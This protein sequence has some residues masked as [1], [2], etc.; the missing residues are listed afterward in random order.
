MRCDYQRT[1]I[2]QPLGCWGTNTEESQRKFLLTFRFFINNITIA[3]VQFFWGKKG[4]YLS[5][6]YSSYRQ[7]FIEN[8]CLSGT[9]GFLSTLW[10]MR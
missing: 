5:I 2:S 3:H 7:M 1:M 4:I 8:D 10:A 6:Q 9:D